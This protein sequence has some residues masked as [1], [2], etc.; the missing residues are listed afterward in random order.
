MKFT[1]LGD[2]IQIKPDEAKSLTDSGMIIPDTAK[3][4][5]V[6]GTVIAKGDKVTQVKISDRVIYSPH[7]GVE[8]TVDGEKILYVKEGD[9]HFVI[10]EN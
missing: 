4:K 10:S 7:A 3:E 9:C 8:V 6:T 1:P 5:P 2:R